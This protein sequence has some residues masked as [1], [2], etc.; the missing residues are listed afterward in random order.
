MPSAVWSRSSRRAKDGRGA[1]TSL[2]GA[3]S[4][5]LTAICLK[6]TARLLTNEEIILAR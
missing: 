4:V 5:L 3:V 6:G 1:R 2:P